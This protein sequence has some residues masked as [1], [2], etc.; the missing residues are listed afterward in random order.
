[1]DIFVF[2]S[3]LMGRHGAGSALEARRRWG[4]VYGRGVGPQG[5]SYAIPTKDFDL[6]TLPLN[7]IQGYVEEFIAY[8]KGRP[9]RTFHICRIGCGLAGYTDGEIGPMFKDSPANVLLP[10]RWEHWRKRT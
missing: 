10:A 2:G 4:A 3:N 6:R 1:M 8:A 5:R 7:H 9:D